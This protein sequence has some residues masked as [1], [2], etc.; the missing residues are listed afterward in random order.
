M[1]DTETTKIEENNELT[2]SDLGDVKKSIVE[3]VDVT[4]P[5]PVPV[6]AISSE[7]VQKSDADATGYNRVK[8][9]T[10]KQFLNETLAVHTKNAQT[11]SNPIQAQVVKPR[12][13]YESV[14]EKDK[15]DF[16]INLSEL[17]KQKLQAKKETFDKKFPKD[18]TG[19]IKH[20]KILGDKLVSSI[21][22]IRNV[23]MLRSSIRSDPISFVA[24][25]NTD[26]IK[27][28]VER[29]TDSIKEKK[30]KKQSVRVEIKKL[31]ELTKKLE[32]SKDPLAN[33]NS[34]IDILKEKE[35]L[36]DFK[37]LLENKSKS[38]V[39]NQ[40]LLFL[41]MYDKKE[42][43]QE[44]KNALDGKYS[45]TQ[46]ETPTAGGKGKTKKNKINKLI[47]RKTRSIK[48]SKKNKTRH[49]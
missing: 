15:D 41:I 8:N 29:L 40:R 48:Q 9:Q 7:I 19:V 42:Y 36:A 13:A 4:A 32:L 1:E 38:G 18:T 43:D 5:A 16:L 2:V 20:Y 25:T 46:S 34:I 44:L 23:N 6:T 21:P 37:K 10:N 12:K 49:R 24:F 22:L 27:S 31:Q 39:V 47:L 28:H 33:F 3:H 30:G 45:H 17:F 26:E 11:A 35:Q 14:S